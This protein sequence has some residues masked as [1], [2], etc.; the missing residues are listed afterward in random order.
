MAA[1]LEA[2]DVLGHP[3]VRGELACG[4]LNRRS[5]LLTA[6]REHTTPDVARVRRLVRVKPY[7]MENP[8]T[9]NELLPPVG[10]GLLSNDD[11]A[12]YERAL[13]AFLES[14]WDDA[15][16]LLH[17]V[18]PDDRGKDVL[19]EFILKYNR[20]PPTNWHGVIPLGS[21]S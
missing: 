13:D 15:Y 18:P 3:F 2:G 7:G 12:A 19:M 6:L 14:D 5:E 17:R 9:V 8:L 16:N 10:G 21:K 11:I 4:N 20:T 1:L